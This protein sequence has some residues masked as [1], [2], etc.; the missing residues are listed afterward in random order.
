MGRLRSAPTTKMSKRARM[1]RKSIKL[2]Y[3]SRFPKVSAFRERVLPPAFHAAEHNAYKLGAGPSRGPTCFRHGTGGR[4]RWE[5]ATLWM[6]A[7][8]RRAG[9]DIPVLW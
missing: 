8:H 9:V 6:S 1:E 5:G 3:S 7:T 4:G 2:A